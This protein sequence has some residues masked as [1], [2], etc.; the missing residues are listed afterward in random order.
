LIKLSQ[1]NRKT[2]TVIKFGSCTHRQTMKLE[3]I[4]L[5]FSTP[6]STHGTGLGAQITHFPAT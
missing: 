1:F 5:V 6:I 4:G 2:P 3:T